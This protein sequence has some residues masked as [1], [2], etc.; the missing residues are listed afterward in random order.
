MPRK[1]VL[2]SMLPLLALLL[3]PG[4]PQKQAAAPDTVVLL[5]RGSTDHLDTWQKAVDA[6][7]EITKTKVSL[8]IEPDATYFTKL[9]ALIDAGT[10]PD[11]AVIDATRF[12]EFA[13]KGRLEPLN[14]MLQAQTDLKLSDF[15]PLALH[16][17]Q[18]QGATYGLPFDISV[19][20]V[21][22]NQDLFELAYLKPPP[23]TWTWQDFLKYA[24]A[25]TRD[26]DDNGTTNVWGTSLPQWWQV[27][28]WQNG[29][30]VVDDA[31][32]PQHSTL[33]TPAAQQALQ[34]LADLSVKEKVAPP[35][36][37]AEATQPLEAFRAGRV[38]MTFIGCDAVTALNN[39]TDLRWSSLR[40]PRG[41]TAANLGLAS[42]L[43][44]LKGSK[45][46][47]EAW[48]LIAYLAGTD[49]QKLLLGGSF[50]TPALEAMVSSEYFAGAGGAGGNPYVAGLKVV[51]PLPF[52][53]RYTEIAAI[54][55][56]ELKALW[57]GQATVQDVTGRIDQR[58]DALLQ[59]QPATAWLL[60]LTPRS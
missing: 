44:L 43:C 37:K 33:S 59:T 41:K 53:P 2:L 45:H 6:F 13:S 38:A 14:P 11:V 19:L 46:Q 39:T 48:K 51:R 32:N 27:N 54:W 60:P 26:T 10:A 12:P 7:T 16:S 23:P 22:Y 3:L 30:D 28:V 21:A 18:Y 40:M 56:Q 34:Y 15:I 31:T 5:V 57:S 25:L 42:G 58:V 9:Q 1:S 50:T 47:Q 49:G 35:A 4:C 55:D 20:S 36:S 17:F 24:K 8:Q 52:T 29:G